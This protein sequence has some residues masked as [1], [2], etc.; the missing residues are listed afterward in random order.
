MRSENWQLVFPTQS[1]LNLLDGD[2]HR[3]NAAQGN[4]DAV[5]VQC[6]CKLFWDV[7][8]AYKQR[9]NP[10]IAT[11]SLTASSICSITLGRLMLSFLRLTVKLVQQH[12][13]IQ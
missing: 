10:A 7:L 6:L 9:K 13:Q 1:Q 8:M 2:G 11:A 4:T 12:A 5:P 3:L